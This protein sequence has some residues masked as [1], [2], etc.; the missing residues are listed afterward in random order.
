MKQYRAWDRDN[1]LFEMVYKPDDVLYFRMVDDPRCCID[2][3]V[4]FIDSDYIV[5]EGLGIPDRDGK[6]IYRGDIL[7][8]GTTMAEPCT[9]V[10]KQVN[11]RYE[12]QGKIHRILGHSFC[13]FRIVGNIHQGILK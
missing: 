13:L 11:A 3:M 6:E 12:A 10:Y 8:D 5:E 4:P 1:N 2:F 9:V 7:G